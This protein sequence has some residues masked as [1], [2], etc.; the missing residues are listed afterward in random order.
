MRDKS[1]IIAKYVSSSAL[2]DGKT[3]HIT[4]LKTLNATIKS[5]R[6]KVFESR[7]S[8][9]LSMTDTSPQSTTHPCN[10][11]WQEFNST[12]HQKGG[13]AKESASL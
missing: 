6:V 11:Y 13:A 2:R 12:S 9:S 1:A 10:V 5:A 7:G 8:L 3:W 4:S